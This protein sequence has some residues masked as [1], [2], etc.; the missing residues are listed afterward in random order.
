MHLMWERIALV[1]LLS[2]FGLFIFLA[3][4]W[5]ESSELLVFVV[6]FLMLSCISRLFGR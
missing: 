1:F 5:P 4:I 2:G 6:F 3:G